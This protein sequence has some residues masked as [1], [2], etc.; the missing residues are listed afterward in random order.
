[1]A[2]GATAI[3][4][5]L[6]CLHT[7]DTVPPNLRPP[8]CPARRGHHAEAVSLI[9]LIGL[10]R[11]MRFIKRRQYVTA[12]TQLCGRYDMVHAIVKRRSQMLAAALP[13]LLYS[14]TCA[15]VSRIAVRLGLG[16]RYLASLLAIKPT[17]STGLPALHSMIALGRS[18][19]DQQLCLRYWVVWAF[20]QLSVGL[21]CSVPFASRI[22][23]MA[24]PLVK[25]WPELEEVPFYGYLWLLIPGLHGTTV[26]YGM[27]AP[28]LQ[29]R[30]HIAS[31]L[32]P[33]IPTRVVTLM[34][35]VL[36]SVLGMERSAAIAEAVHEI[37]VLLWGA[38]FLLTPTPI[39][40]IGLLLLALGGPMLRSIE[41][42]LPAST[43]QPQLQADP[44]VAAGSS[45]HP[46]DKQLRYWLSYTLMCGAL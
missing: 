20:V 1:M 22:W 8:H 36:A 46:T 41:I 21:L 25:R 28:E 35:M 4:L 24:S 12:L 16:P 6:R 27:I 3:G 10:W 34:Q 9:L 39:A 18:E 15:A 26:A 5:S 32:L 45:L 29:R 37:S 40:T 43:S 14:A 23:G 31:T 42:L 30:A 17:V 13:H 2:G 11:L 44:R 19:D 38:A 33:S 7:C